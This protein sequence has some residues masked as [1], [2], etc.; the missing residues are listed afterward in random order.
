MLQIYICVG[1]LKKEEIFLKLWTSN[2]LQ[3]QSHQM[4]VWSIE[5]VEHL[6]AFCRVIIDYHS[7][8]SG[9][10]ILDGHLAELVYD[11]SMR[12]LDKDIP[13]LALC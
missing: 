13:P 3:H 2:F 6:P 11:I 1:H 10:K 8:S 5:S 9:K 4:S 7:A 12:N